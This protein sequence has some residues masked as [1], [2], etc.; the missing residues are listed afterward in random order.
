MYSMETHVKNPTGLHSRPAQKL[1]ALSN[2]FESDIKLITNEKIIDPKSIFSVLGGALK[3]GTTITV[4][5]EGKDEQNAVIA[6]VKY[7][8]ELNE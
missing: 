3:Q 1:V 2:M 6:V 4:Q 5:A 7:I 8:E